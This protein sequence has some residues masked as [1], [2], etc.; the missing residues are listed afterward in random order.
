[1]TMMRN[2]S[3]AARAELLK[4]KKEILETNLQET[5]PNGANGL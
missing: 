1:M 5:V 4:Q 2:T 3:E